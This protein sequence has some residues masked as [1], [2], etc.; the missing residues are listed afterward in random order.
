MACVETK[1]GHL[2]LVK[3]EKWSRLGGVHEF[4]SEWVRSVSLK[5]GHWSCLF[6][7]NGRE[8]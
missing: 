8:E 2:N 1:V 6:Y 3:K 7:V 4:L 5:F